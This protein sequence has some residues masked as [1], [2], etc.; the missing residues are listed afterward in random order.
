MWRRRC[1]ITAAIVFTLSGC[2]PAPVRPIADCDGAV[3]GLVIDAREVD[4]RPAMA[5]KVL[6]ERGQEVYGPSVVDRNWVVGQGMA[7]YS[8]DF[9]KAV[10]H[11]R[12]GSN[13]LIVK[14]VAVSGDNRS[15]VVAA[16]DAGAIRAAFSRCPE[17]LQQARVL[18]VVRP[19]E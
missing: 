19:R 6:G 7:G 17:F 16:K 18:F 12:V 5:P 3:S 9:E 11:E 1:A 10:R 8:P 4:L 15:A 13:P 2:A 14:A